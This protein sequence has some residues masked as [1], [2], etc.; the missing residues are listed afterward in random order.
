[1]T[2]KSTKAE[3]D[4]RVALVAEMILS[5]YIYTEIVRYGTK[6][7]NV[8]SRQIDSYV[9]KATEEIS[10]SAEKHHNKQFQIAV[11]RLTKLYRKTIEAKKYTISLE[12]QREIS[13]LFGLYAPKKISMEVLIGD[14][15]ESE[16]DTNIRELEAYLDGHSDGAEATTPSPAKETSKS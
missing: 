13:K 8:K 4:T 12:C 11:N 14:L 15:E 5:G 9:S 1:M 16:I 2:K 7:W 3:V 6:E 10:K